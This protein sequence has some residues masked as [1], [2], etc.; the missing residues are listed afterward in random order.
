MIKRRRKVAKQFFPDDLTVELIRLKGMQV[1]F[2]R[3]G[4]VS[5]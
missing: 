3:R 2:P 4:R 1:L 5:L